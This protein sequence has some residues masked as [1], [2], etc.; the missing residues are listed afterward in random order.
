MLRFLFPPL[1]LLVAL[2]SAIVGFSMLAFGGP[3]ASVS[4]HEARSQGDE[5]S[6]DTLEAD[7]AT[8]QTNRV[9]LISSLFATSGV[10]T[11]VA[12]GSMRGSSQKRS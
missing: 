9:V 5:L 12:F 7:L 1:C 3:E 4:L 2:A 6:T 10:M 11:I 8:R